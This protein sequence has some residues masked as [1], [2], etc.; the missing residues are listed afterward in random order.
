MRIPNMT[1][2]TIIPKNSSTSKNPDLYLRQLLLGPMENF[3]YLIGSRQTG[4]CFVVDPAWDVEAIKRAAAADGMRLKGALL[5]HYHPDHCGGHLWGHD[6]E[7]VAELVGSLSL[8]VYAHR[9]ELEGLVKITGLSRQDFKACESGDKLSIG[10]QE[11]TFIH[12]P[13]HTPGSQ[14]FLVGGNL[15]AGDT[16]FISGCGR[17]DLPG[18]SS[19]KLYESISTKL[20]TLPGNTVLYPGHNYDAQPSASLDAIKVSNPYLSASSLAN[21]QRLFAR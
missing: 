14:C 3:V 16:L 17:V 1:T 10:N 4:E 8:P 7:G 11:V 12:T 2:N 13:G 15:V 19:E 20:A 5:T 6:I 18:G 21:W 9:E